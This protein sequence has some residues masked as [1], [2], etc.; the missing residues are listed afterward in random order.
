MSQFIH[1]PSRD[2]GVSDVASDVDS[3]VIHDRASFDRALLDTSFD[4]GLELCRVLVPHNYLNCLV[5][6]LDI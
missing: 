3:L 2:Q 5:D 1:S 6:K 4:V